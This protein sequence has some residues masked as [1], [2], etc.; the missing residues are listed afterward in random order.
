MRPPKVFP[1]L[2]DIAGR[3]VPRPARQDW[4]AERQRGLNA[5]W[6]LI[7]RGELAVNAR[8]QLADFCIDA[9]T[10]ALWLRFNREGLRR[11]SR[12][13]GMVVAGGVTALLLIAL[14]SQGFSTSQ[15]LVELARGSR[16]AP[17]WV[18]RNHATGMV[19]FG[20]LA[21]ILM[22]WATSILL[23]TGGRI[24]PERGGWRYWSFLF[25]KS[26]LILAVASML[27][28]EGG[29]ALRSVIPGPGL[30]RLL[31]GIVL[32]V[33]FVIASACGALWSLADQRRRCPACQRL[34]QMPVA[35]GSWASTFDPATTELVCDRG[36]GSLSL[37]EAET[38]EADRWTKLDASW[39]SLFAT[40]PDED[41]ILK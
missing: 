23:L 40:T 37:L 10:S 39:L 30:S 6:T 27:W 14:A 36:H 7:E 9:F 32:A 24:S 21:P 18:G 1:R 41:K 20:Y 26:T 12:G 31:G 5:L 33:I 4:L 17:A 29:S 28:V 2:L 8:A 3:I 22:A 15:R 19:L 38:A 25:A 13:P 35:F 11:W 34:L 16:P